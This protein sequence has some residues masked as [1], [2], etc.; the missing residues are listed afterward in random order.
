MA[1]GCALFVV[2]LILVVLDRIGFLIV[3]VFFVVGL[4]FV[5]TAKGCQ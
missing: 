4:A 5:T 1:P 3:L 2:F